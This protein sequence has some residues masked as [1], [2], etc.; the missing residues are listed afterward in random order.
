M[1]RFVAKARHF[2]QAAN[3]MAIEVDEDDFF[4]DAEKSFVK[5]GIREALKQEL[6]L[7]AGHEWAFI[8][9][10][11]IEPFSRS[12]PMDDGEILFSLEDT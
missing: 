5:E 10:M 6:A 12:A 1:M 3:D 7:L 8:H 2:V 9:D 4:S 11:K